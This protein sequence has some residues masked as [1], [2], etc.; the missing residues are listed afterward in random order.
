MD[1]VHPVHI[2][3]NFN[4]KNYQ[5]GLTM[6]RL[7]YKGYL[8]SC[9]PIKSTNDWQLEIEKSGREIVHTWSINSSKTL[10]SIENF[11]FDQ[12]DKKVLEEQNQ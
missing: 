7:S 6:P 10:K 9:K 1:R 5:K 3:H 2:R 8:I 4:V 11:A 12:I